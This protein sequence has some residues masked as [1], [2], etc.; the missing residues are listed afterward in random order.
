MKTTLNILV[1]IRKNFTRATL[2]LIIVL[3]CFFKTNAVGQ[4]N[5]P[6]DTAVVN[7]HLSILA[8][9]LIEIS[10]DTNVEEFYYSTIN[11]C[12]DSYYHMYYR[13]L[14]N[15]Y[16]EE[17][18]IDLIPRMN[19]FIETYLGEL[20]EGENIEASLNELDAIGFSP[21]IVI[22]NYDSLKDDPINENPRIGYYSFQEEWPLFCLSCEDGLISQDEVYANRAWFVNLLPTPIYYPAVWITNCTA[23]SAIANGK[24][25]CEFCPFNSN[26]LPFTH[27]NCNVN[28]WEVRITNKHY[29]GDP[30]FG[31]LDRCIYGVLIQPLTYIN[32]VE[33]NYAILTKLNGLDYYE[34]NQYNTDTI[35]SIKKVQHPIHDF[36]HFS[37]ANNGVFDVSLAGDVLTL[38]GSEFQSERL[39][40]FPQKI[41]R[42]GLASGGV[43]RLYR[44]GVTGNRPVY[45]SVPWAK[46]LWYT[47]SPDMTIHYD[48]EGDYPNE[49]CSV[50]AN[51]DKEELFEACGCEFCETGKAVFDGQLTDAMK[52]VATTNFSEI[53]NFWKNNVVTVG[54]FSNTTVNAVDNYVEFEA[55]YSSSST[56][57]SLPISPAPTLIQNLTLTSSNRYEVYKKLV[58]GTSAVP[59]GTDL[60]ISV[61]AKF[62]NGEYITD[63]KCLNVQNDDVNRVSVQFRGNIKD[64]QSGITNYQILIYY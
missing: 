41:M 22:M 27:S 62:T 52:Y 37:S 45:F 54:V 21:Q 40:E 39:T 43:Y 25:P 36:E 2:L 15:L 9:G 4:E 20:Y 6:F 23:L 51:I 7:K 26:Y 64:Y 11:Y 28:N 30:L 56:T 12:I 3:T 49:Y 24:E 35:M 17:K 47:S 61:I 63:T 31:E 38:C 13:N 8:I 33:G 18:H 1:F 44:P 48:M 29:N 34:C 58:I 59:K 57:C 32:S 19:E 46:G 5:N 55:S 14:L 42:Y 50:S 16:N 53:Y 10:T 60:Y